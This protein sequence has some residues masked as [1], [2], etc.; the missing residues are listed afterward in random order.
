MGVRFVSVSVGFHRLAGKGGVELLL[1]AGGEGYVLVHLGEDF[2]IVL[3][4]HEKGD[5]TMK[6]LAIM[7]VAGIDLNV[8][9]ILV[10]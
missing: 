4:V 6:R 3:I 2:I 1:L 10:L 9:I 5:V 7:V 8:R